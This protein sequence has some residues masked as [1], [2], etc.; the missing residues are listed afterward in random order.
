MICPH[1]GEEENFH[2]NYDYTQKHMPIINVLCNECG[3]FFNSK[4]QQKKLITEIMN[5]D[6][7]DGLYD[8]VNELDK[9]AEKTFK[10]DDATVFVQREIWKDGYKKAQETL[11]TEE[12]VREA[13]SMARKLSGVAYTND[14]IIQSLK[15]PKKDYG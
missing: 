15:Q 10:G 12:Q 3:E 8:T 4:E 2:F 14:E 13:M 7:K 9:L 6:A 11:Y 5:A 1:C